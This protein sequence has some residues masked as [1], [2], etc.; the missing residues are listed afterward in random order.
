MSLIGKSGPSN[1]E[2]LFQMDGEHGGPGDMIH[3]FLRPFERAIVA[4]A[5]KICQVAM[6]IIPKGSSLTAEQ[7]V[8]E[9]K[10]KDAEIVFAMEVESAA[11]GFR[12]SAGPACRYV[13]ARDLSEDEWQVF[14]DLI[15]GIWMSLGQDQIKSLKNTFTSKEL[16]C[17][18]QASVSPIL[19]S[20]GKKN[21]LRGTEMSQ[22]AT[23]LLEHP[24][25]ELLFSLT[26]ADA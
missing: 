6:P 13:L 25:N 23:Q 11:L 19:R 10:E 7:A 16:A 4:Q 14:M 21:H 2:T 22:R 5:S 1:F 24:V 20:I 8:D 26:R 12:S 9:A 3:G 17:Q 18:V 15:R